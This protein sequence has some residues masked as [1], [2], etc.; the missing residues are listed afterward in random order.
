[1]YFVMQHFIRN[2]PILR[3]SPCKTANMQPAQ[4]LCQVG[5]VAL[6]YVILCK[7][8]LKAATEKISIDRLILIETALEVLSS[9]RCF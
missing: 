7:L 2:Y 4:L 9:Q 1:M 8:K 5:C 6:Y 3:L